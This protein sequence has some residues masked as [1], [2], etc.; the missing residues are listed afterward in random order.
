M[1]EN[2]LLAPYRKRIGRP[3]LHDGTIVTDVPNLMWG[4]GRHS[5]PHSRGRLGLGF[6]AI[7]H[8]NAECVG[9]HV[10]KLGTRYEVLQPIAAGMTAIY[11]SLGPDVARGLSLRKDHGSQYTCEHFLAQ[12]RFWGIDPGFAFVEE[13]QTNGVA[14]R[15]NRTLKEQAI[16]GRVFVGI[17][18]VRCAVSDFVTL[19]DNRW[20]LERLGYLSPAEARS[21][22]L[23]KR[24]G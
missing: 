4:D 7:E 22:T 13:P 16:H 18:D 14:E 24:A 23:R 20:R 17:D 5:H 11:G 10:I 12:V 3:L 2:P 6:T 8:W 15:F 19:W 21:A 1:R 9:W